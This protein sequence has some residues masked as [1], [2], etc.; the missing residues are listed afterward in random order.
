M[1]F[2]PQDLYLT[3]GTVAII[4]DWQATVTKFDSSSFYNWEEDN[5]PI[6]DLED[7]TSYIWER[8]GYPIRDGFSGIPGKMFVVSSDYGF[9]V[10]QDSSGIVF[11][12]LS[13][14]INVLPNPIT[15]P[16]IIEVASFGNL[17]ELN[18]NNIK[19]DDSCPGAGLEI[20]NRVFARSKFGS[21]AAPSALY[22]SS[23]PSV[24]SLMIKE[25][26]HNASALAISSVV[27]SATTDARLN[28]NNR[29]WVVNYAYGA[30]SLLT[31]KPILSF[32][33]SQF[34]QSIA[35]N[36]FAIAEYGNTQD[37]TIT[38]YDVAVTDTISGAA[39]ARTAIQDQSNVAVLAFGNFLSNVKVSNCD[40]PIFIRGFLVDGSLDT[41]GTITQSI[42][43]GFNIV[44]SDVVLENVMSMRCKKHGFKI[45]N[46]NV[47]VRRAIVAAR[48]YEISS[49]SDRSANSN[50][51]GLYAENS[52]INF[53]P[54][55]T[56]YVQYS[57]VDL[58]SQFAFNDVGIQLNNSKI[59]GGNKITTS[60]SVADGPTMIQSLYNKRIGLEATNSIFDHQGGLEIIN[61]YNGIVANN[62]K[63]NFPLLTVENNQ[64][65]GLE[66][67]N[68]DI[69]LN[70]DLIRPT[71]TTSYENSQIG[72]TYK[73]FTFYRNG[74]H[75]V[76]N[77]S[78]LRYPY[79]TSMP[80][81][82]GNI[83][84]IDSFGSYNVSG[85]KGRLPAIEIKNSSRAELIHPEIKTYQTTSVYAQPLF[86]ACLSISDNSKVVL[87]GSGGVSPNTG[88][89][90]LV[91]PQTLAAQKKAAVVYVSKNSAVTFNGNTLISQGAVDVLAEDNSIVN[92][93]PHKRDN[94]TL[95]VSGWNLS[96][97]QNHT[98][99]ELHAIKS[100]LVADKNSVI[101]MEDIGDYATH[102]GVAALPSQDY[103][104]S[105]V[106][107]TTY[108]TSGGYVQFYPNPQDD[109]LLTGTNLVPAAIGS[110]AYTETSPGYFLT[111]YTDANSP[112]NIS[113]YSKGGICVKAQN[114]S[115]VKAL[116]VNFAAG[117]YN[118]SSAFYDSSSGNCE[119]LRIWNICQNSELE[120]AYLSVS[121]MY[122]SL[123]GYYGPSAVYLSGAGVPA[124]GAPSSTPDTSTL[125]VLDFYG[126]S[127]SRAGKN[128]GPF[129]LYFSPHSQ[130]KMLGYVSG[131]GAGQA[132][133]YGAPYQMLAQGY[134]P[135]GNLI[136]ASA[137]DAIYSGISTSAFYYVSAMVDASYKNRVRLDESAADSFANAKHNAIAKSGRHALVTIYRSTSTAGGQ[138]YD[139][140]VAGYGKGFKS[141]E[142]F[143]LRRDD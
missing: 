25:M 136:G 124:S 18:L 117:W 13:S 24:S 65:I 99:V 33:D 57:G 76:L 31:K 41:T 118:T 109:N 96:N 87:R 92:F 6:Y 83:L 30:T 81:K 40:G 52:L 100:C 74:Q 116:N 2:I 68:C 139:S 9:P 137:F 133:F 66:A 42:D 58:I 67:N 138:G 29:S 55:S 27:L 16:I 105:D 103:N 89:T 104:N 39:I 11:R 15:Y 143:D 86:G 106:Y 121:G 70:P 93:G 21:A 114:G 60:F 123:T 94:N 90:M 20:V 53:I 142:I 63:L 72:K 4:N 79:A 101:N 107:N 45:I 10:G 34:D 120:A 75:M 140:N 56:A 84:A 127:S 8:I 46:S 113:N 128:Y 91:G 129:R 1:S 61:N 77:H 71:V 26:F 47:D 73:Q 95:D 7:R 51:I 38:A 108:Y 35:T 98:R 54:V 64:E 69:V 12:D 17:G 50:G 134:N 48:N 32:K 22:I 85:T 115:K 130:A 125:S 5:M 14:V 112:T 80:S 141:A 126:V 3:S 78:I 135:S 62:S 97:N 19:I 28:S 122:P 23:D 119:L 111:P 44:N 88:P 110:Y 102:W 82:V 43:S 132:A 59:V 131:T 37:P 36:K 49:T